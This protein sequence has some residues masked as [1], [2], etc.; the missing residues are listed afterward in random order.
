[1]PYSYQTLTTV[2]STSN[3]VLNIGFLSPDHIFMQLDGEDYGAYTIAGNT[4]L[5]SPAIASGHVIKMFRT[6]PREECIH[7]Y[8]G[9]AQWRPAT[10]DESFTQ[11]LYWAQEAVE[12]P[13]TL[14]DV[15]VGGTL[16]VEGATTLTGD[17]DAL[18]AVHVGTDLTVAGSTD[19]GGELTASSAVVRHLTVF[20]DGTDPNYYN[21]L[22]IAVAEDSATISTP[23][24]LLI[25]AGT[26]L[27]LQDGAREL[28]AGGR[29][30][31]KWTLVASPGASTLSIADT[32]LY[33]DGQY[34]LN[35][36][37]TQVALSLRRGIFTTGTSAL[38]G[39]S[40][41]FSYRVV[42]YDGGD[43]ITGSTQTVTLATG[44][45]S[46]AALTITSVYRL[47]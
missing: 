31:S 5:F 19:V 7:I 46:T 15:I 21:A 14:G 45:L 2:E 26:D 8:D 32:T 44:V 25:D 13:V 1:M 35:M 12:Q 43:T 16:A 4:V 24:T 41:V 9:Q 6:T 17:V 40:G 37:G 47:D 38:T 18:G 36:S 30:I 29:L 11:A 27:R 33:P 22:D 34:L 28:Y 23:G 20:D 10:V 42:S 3:L 39:G